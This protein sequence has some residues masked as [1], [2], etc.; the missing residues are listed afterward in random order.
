MHKMAFEYV[1]AWG[2]D[3]HHLYISV[4]LFFKK[5]GICRRSYL[6]VKKTM[7]SHTALEQDII[8]EL[9]LTKT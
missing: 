8:V 5:Q 7:N 1:W 3:E 4:I 9:Q 6:V 2:P